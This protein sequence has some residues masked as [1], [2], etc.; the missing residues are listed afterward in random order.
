MPRDPVLSTTETA[1]VVVLFIE[2]VFLP[3]HKMNWKSE[4]ATFSSSSGSYSSDTV[5]RSQSQMSP[6]KHVLYESCQTCFVL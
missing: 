4:E 1:T 2:A 3:P 5:A 6:A